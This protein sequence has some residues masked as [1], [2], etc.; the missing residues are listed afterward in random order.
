M[1]NLSLKLID[2]FFKCWSHQSF[3]SFCSL[4]FFSFLR[5]KK[6]SKQIFN[7][8]YKLMLS[9]C[10]VVIE[11]NQ[12]IFG[13]NFFQGNI[14][15]YYGLLQGKIF[16]IVQAPACWIFSQI[17][18]FPCPKLKIEAT[19]SVKTL[20]TSSKS[21]FVFKSLELSRMLVGI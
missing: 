8:I 11:Q 18:L 9:L 16:K 17:T 15:E 12:A 14:A 13:A 19:L 10:N 4:I 7:M 5:I 21:P 3:D 6:L 2:F 1:N 20:C